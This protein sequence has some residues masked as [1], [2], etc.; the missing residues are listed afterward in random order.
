MTPGI[1]I[2][3]TTKGITLTKAS[4]YLPVRPHINPNDA[5]R[6]PDNPMVGSCTYMGKKLTKTAIAK[7]CSGRNLFLMFHNTMRL[8]ARWNTLA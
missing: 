3:Q 1:S 2:V 8:T 7:A 6:K 5:K 4:L